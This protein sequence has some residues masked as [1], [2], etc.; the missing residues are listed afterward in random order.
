MVELIIYMKKKSKNQKGVIFNDMY[1]NAYYV[2]TGRLV[3]EDLL[4]YNGCALPFVP[5]SQNHEIKEEIY[6]DIINHF[7]TTEEYE[8]CAHIKK[9]KDS[10][11]N[12]KN[13]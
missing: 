5:Y 13:S 2:I 9:I 3:V 10:I 12:N 11:Y 6:D 7:I 4:D 8:K 1:K